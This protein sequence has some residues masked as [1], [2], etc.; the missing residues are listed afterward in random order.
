MYQQNPQNQQLMN[1]NYT[2]PP[3][4]QNQQ[5]MNNQATDPNQ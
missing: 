2:Y 5:Y 3:N 1:T 4:V